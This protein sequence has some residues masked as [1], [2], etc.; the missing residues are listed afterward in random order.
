MHVF[1][2]QLCVP[3]TRDSVRMG[4]FHS[5][6]DILTVR[7]RMLSLARCLSAMR[8]EQLWCSFFNCEGI[9]KSDE[10]PLPIAQFSC[11]QE[12]VGRTTVNRG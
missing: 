3:Y 1:A 9:F 10:S 6:Y 12:V 4:E 8:S 5:V 2:L 7:R 11:V